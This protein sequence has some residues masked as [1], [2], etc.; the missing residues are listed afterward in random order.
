MGSLWVLLPREVVNEVITVTV[1]DDDLGVGPVMKMLVGLC[2]WS[3]GAFG[4]R[5]SSDGL[6]YCYCD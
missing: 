2:S 3:R 4:Q 6:H 1:G 5:S